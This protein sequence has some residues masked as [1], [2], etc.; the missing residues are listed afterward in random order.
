MA[1]QVRLG[2]CALRKISSKEKNQSVFLFPVLF[3]CVSGNP[4]E[5]RACFSS[6]CF[7]C[8]CV[9]I[10]SKAERV[11]VHPQIDAPKK[12]NGWCSSLKPGCQENRLPQILKTILASLTQYRH[13]Y[14]RRCASFSEDRESGKCRLILSA[15][16]KQTPLQEEVRM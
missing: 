15:L 6:Q 11:F 12:P 7:F 16:P 3:L 14:R 2:K 5:T 13:R 9:G 4:Q 1:P 8:V 10:I